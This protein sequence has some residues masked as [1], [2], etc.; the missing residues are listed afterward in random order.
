MHPSWATQIAANQPQLDSDARTR[1]C[2][3]VAQNR[4]PGASNGR[5]VVV[6]NSS[7]D[8]TDTRRQ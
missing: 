1:F 4:K 7:A 5:P 8:P 6:A 2:D 3:I